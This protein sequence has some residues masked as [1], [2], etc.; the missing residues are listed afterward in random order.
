MSPAARYD[1]RYRH[2]SAHALLPSY[3]LR[4]A[5]AAHILYSASLRAMLMRDAE[6]RYAYQPG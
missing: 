4:Y 3:I 1:E 2:D 6:R 5:P